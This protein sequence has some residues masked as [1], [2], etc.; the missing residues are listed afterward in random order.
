[1][2]DKSEPEIQNNSPKVTWL[3]PINN[4]MYNQGLFVSVITNIH[5]T[6]SNKRYIKYICHSTYFNVISKVYLLC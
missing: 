2:A 3:N 1:M 4:H 6:I 5:L